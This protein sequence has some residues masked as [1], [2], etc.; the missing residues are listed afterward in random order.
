LN[1]L[2]LRGTLKRFFG[3][4][5]AQIYVVLKQYKYKTPTLETP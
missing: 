2:G 5:Q 4:L 3:T 1:P